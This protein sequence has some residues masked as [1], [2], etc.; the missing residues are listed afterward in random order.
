MSSGRS[1]C[2]RLSLDREMKNVT[3]EKQPPLP[4]STHEEDDSVAT[5]TGAIIQQTT[6]NVSKEG[7]C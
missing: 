7:S 6:G 2:D 3:K 5:L 4:A 1:G